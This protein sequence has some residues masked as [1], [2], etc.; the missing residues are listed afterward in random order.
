MSF[1]L[2]HTATGVTGSVDIPIRVPRWARGILVTVRRTAGSNGTIYPA[3]GANDGGGGGFF[4]IT[5]SL[6][7]IDLATTADGRWILHQEAGAHSGSINA[8]AQ[9]RFPDDVILRM[10]LAGSSGATFEVRVDWIR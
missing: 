5:G 8:H 2:V 9:T 3:I 7:T 10:V 6:T 4:Q 1:A